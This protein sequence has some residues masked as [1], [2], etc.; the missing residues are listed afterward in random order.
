V[1]RV[2]RSLTAYH[3]ARTALKS[4]GTANRIARAWASATTSHVA[5]PTTTTQTSYKEYIM[6][7]GSLLILTIFV[8]LSGGYGLA[9]LFDTQ[10]IM[11]R[12]QPSEKTHEKD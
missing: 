1:N 2:P 9:S 8:V 6:F 11:D 7:I 4:S 12:E 3:A 5:W 10:N